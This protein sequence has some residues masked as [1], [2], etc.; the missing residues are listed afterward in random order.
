MRPA[1]VAPLIRQVAAV[2]QSRADP[3]D[4]ALIGCWVS[5]G[6]SVGLG[7]EG[8][9][10]DWAATVPLGAD[11]PHTGGLVQALIV[12]QERASRVTVCGFLVDTYCLGVK[13]CTGPLTMGAGSVD[14]YRRSFFRA[15]ET[16]ELPAPL[17][18]IQQLV[19][20]AVAYA[21]GLGFEPA[22]DFGSTSPFLGTS[23]APNPI[24]FGRDG[25]PFYISGPR[26]DPG[27]VRAVLDRTVGAGNYQFLTHV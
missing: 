22:A 24:R 3:G 7:L 15:F 23:D 6:W 9:G 12:R 18:L 4:R 17:E 19:H 16:P 20:G 26:D 1:E 25:R 21:R 5:P 14:D 10:A 11:E 2:Q 8:A 27:A 13:N